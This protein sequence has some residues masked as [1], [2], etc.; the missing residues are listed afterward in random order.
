M[1]IQDQ[2]YNSLILTEVFEVLRPLGEWN[3]PARVLADGLVA[4]HDGAP[5]VAHGLAAQRHEHVEGGQRGPLVTR[6]RVEAV[7]SIPGLLTHL[8]GDYNQH[9]EDENVLGFGL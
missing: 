5:H 1:A 9:D 3:E 6:P 8:P 4:E 2:K 7:L